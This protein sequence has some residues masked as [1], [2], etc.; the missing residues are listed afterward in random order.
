MTNLIC[1]I[2]AWIDFDKI[3]WGICKSL[4]NIIYL[5]ENVFKFAVGASD[6][7]V[8]EGGEATTAND[9]LTG[10]FVELF[11]S[12]GSLSK[13]YYNMA[14]LCMTLM[15]I[16]VIIGILKAVSAKETGPSIG[17]MTGRAFVSMFKMLLV[18]PFF[19]FA[20]LLTGYVFQAL[21]VIMG[22][23]ESSSSLAEIL[24]ECFRTNSAIKWN[25][26]Y[27]VVSPYL[28][29][30]G[31]DYVLCIL[32]SCC[33]IVTLVTATLA[34]TKRFVKIFSYYLTA[35]MV[36]S[37]SMLDEGKSWELWKDNLL[38]QLLG[39]GGVI[40]AMYIFIRVTP[41]ITNA[42][43]ESTIRGI[44]GT[45]TSGAVL[46]GIL[47]IVFILGMSTVP[48]GSTAFMAQLVSQGAGQNE[49][50]DLMHTQQMMGNGIR[51]AG[52]AVGKAIGGSLSA[53]AGG[54]GGAGAM[55]SK[56]MGA[57]AGGSG[58][59]AS[60]VNMAAGGNGAAG[61]LANAA[62]TVAGGAANMMG[63]G[64]GGS[65]SG[66]GAAGTAGT[67][68]KATK[69]FAGG[70]T[71]QTAGATSAA[72]S[73]VG[74]AQ[75]QAFGMNAASMA[76]GFV[77]GGNGAS[78]QSESG[79]GGN[80][81]GSGGL[82][83]IKNSS[84][85]QAQR[86]NSAAHRGGAQFAI[87]R[88]G[89][90]GAAGYAAGRIVSHAGTAIGSL[91]KGAGKAAKNKIG[92][93]QSARS[94]KTLAE[95]NAERKGNKIAKASTKQDSKNN[96]TAERRQ[97]KAQNPLN[98]QIVKDGGNTGE[99][100]ANVKRY[101]DTQLNNLEQK[102]Q[103]VEHTLQQSKYVNASDESKNAYRRQVLGGDMNKLGRALGRTEYGRS[104]DVQNRFRAINDGGK[105]PQGN[106]SKA[107]V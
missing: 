21:I 7:F 4:M 85:M 42:I 51:L 22:A 71:G 68:A 13:A 18:P 74:E 91:A 43:D 32:T 76:A 96:R 3:W 16:F 39:A 27:S 11:W 40:I 87:S 49:S 75:G 105:K 5:L 14:I 86:M 78:P 70:A 9:L 65:A 57:F 47:K 23:A 81:G 82:N 101:I 38:A 20:L 55:T 2:S 33:L 58:G 88:G 17:K 93:I 79:S 35:P 103:K 45:E 19:M 31:F 50:N 84:F 46:K 15:I 28:Q 62:R 95:I 52:M 99:N 83:R 107:D 92:E 80:T 67:L 12:D 77:N 97:E 1:D 98:K 54:T 89:I 102:A 48:A 41:I 73:G 26:E 10:T 63:G 25:S 69:S 30:G 56:M 72:A 61:T 100:A 90:L 36:L 29:D 37:K 24:C 104:A 34:V 64:S 8:T 59:A 106:D 66:G 94:G 53:L 60:P 44:E 6:S